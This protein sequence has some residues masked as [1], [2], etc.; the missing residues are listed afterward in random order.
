[1]T[2]LPNFRSGSEFAAELDEKDE[3]KHLR[4]KFIFPQWQNRHIIY[5]TGNSLGLQPSTFADELQ[6][7]A[8]DWSQWGVEGHFHA[9][10]PWYSYH[11]KFA[12]P[13]ARLVGGKSEEVVVMNQ[14]TVNLHLLM[15]SFYRPSGKRDKILFE[16]KPFPSDRYAFM[17]QAKLHDLDPDEVLIEMHSDHPHGIV[18]EDALIAKIHELGD[19]LALVCMGGVNYYTGQLFDM[20]RITEAAHRV[21]AFCGFDLAH[22]AGNVPLSLHDWQVDFACWCS[23]KYLNSGPGAA[24]GAFVHE[25]HAQRKD[26]FRLAGWWGHDKASRFEMGNEFIPIPTAESWALSNAPV[27]NMIGLAE[28]LQVF[29]LT[30][31]QSLRK[32]SVWLTSYLEFLLSDVAARTKRKIE[33][34]TPIHS[35][36]RGCQ[37]SIAIDGTDKNFVDLMWKEGVL[38]DWRAPGVVRMAPVP[39]YNSFTDVWEASCA[40]EKVLSRPH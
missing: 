24:G 21:G 7:E 36:Q 37:L 23:Y 32:K 28:S 4:S 39:L 16:Y 15:M 31:M 27:F 22:A 1:M 11:E 6:R 30:D 34:I 33:L 14:L 3:L 13:L 10:Y 8:K 9:K 5:F 26:L 29:S 12:E 35:A 40:L 2:K 19:E 38:I 17:S 25:R 20:K 18:N